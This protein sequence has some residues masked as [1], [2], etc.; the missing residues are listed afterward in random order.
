MT[1][2]GCQVTTAS[3]ASVPRASIHASKRFRA[4]ARAC[5]ASGTDM[6]TIFAL[7]KEHL[8]ADSTCYISAC[9][10][11][12]RS[13]PFF[14]HLT[15]ALLRPATMIGVH[16]TAKSNLC[17]MWKVCGCAPVS[18]AVTMDPCRACSA[19][20]HASDSQIRSID[21]VVGILS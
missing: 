11:A 8:C 10:G 12:G 4:R 1:L 9:G 13:F 3:N 5:L 17:C 19:L 15:A 14:L 18:N 20:M 16:S 2:D 6:R 7:V 21:E